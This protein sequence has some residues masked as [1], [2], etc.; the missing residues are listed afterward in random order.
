MCGSYRYITTQHHPSHCTQFDRYPNVFK[1]CKDYFTHN[2]PS[3]KLNILSF[4]CSTGEECFTLVKYF[5]TSKIVG[6]DF[7][8]GVL[9]LCNKNNIYPNI[10][11]I[12]SADICSATEKYDM[13]FCMSVL[14][15]WLL[16]VYK[17][18][19]SDIYE[20]STFQ[21]IVG[22]LHN[23]LQINGLMII[24]NS[25]YRF[26]D[27]SIY[28]KYKVLCDQRIC[29]SGFVNK[30]DRNGNL[31]NEKYQDCIFIKTND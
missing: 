22:E 11:F 9:E 31:L 30:F 3:K 10:S 1:V 25:N 14:C 26:S 2:F 24:Y 23:F 20:F 4:G 15:K 21:G 13:I 18:N 7:D 12:Y 28:H 16:T 17:K 27:T 29:E 8:K 5:P 6:I 19:I